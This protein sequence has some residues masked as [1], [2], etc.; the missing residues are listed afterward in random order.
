[1]PVTCAGTALKVRPTERASNVL[2]SASVLIS[3]LVRMR[4]GR[5]EQTRVS[6]RLMQAISLGEGEGQR[7]IAVLRAIH[8]VG[9]QVDESL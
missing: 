6:A 1:M 3:R 9:P 5:A 4:R 8:C 2:G 7:E